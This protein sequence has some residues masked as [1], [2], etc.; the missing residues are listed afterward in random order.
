LGYVSRGIEKNLCREFR[1]FAR[2][3]LEDFCPSFFGL[4]VSSGR[5]IA[6]EI[7]VAIEFPRFARDKEEAKKDSRAFA[8]F[9]ARFCF[10]SPLTLRTL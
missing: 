1:E 3:F 9:V 5:T 8:K 7:F 10:Y 4:A 2:I 6:H